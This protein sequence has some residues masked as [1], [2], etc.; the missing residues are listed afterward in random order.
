MLLVVAD[1][2]V[3]FLHRFLVAHPNLV[4]DLVDEAEVVADEDEPPFVV[5][6]G[7]GEGI[8]GLDV[9]MVRGL[10]EEEEV[11][12]RHA[13]HR[14]DDSALLALAQVAD[15]RGL[16][17]PGDAIAP[18]KRAPLL[19]VPRKLLVVRV[20]VLEELER[21]HL[22]LE[23]IDRVLMVLPDGEVHVP[24][25]GPLRRHELA[26][27][28]LEESRLARAVGAHERHPRVAV[29][30]EVQ[31]LVQVVL[32][33]P[34]VREADV[35][36]GHHGGRQL[37][38]VREGE[39][40][41]LLALH[42]RGEALRVHLVQ[43]L[44]LRLGLLHEVGVGPA[45]G[46]ELLDVLDV[47]LL[48]LVLLLL[49]DVV[50]GDRLLEGVVVAG[51]VVQLL[52][53]EPYG[54]RADAVEEVLAVRDDDEALV[55]VLQVLLEPH[56]RLE[57]EV[58]GRL[59]EQQQRRPHKKRPREGH[60]HAPSPRHV[61]RGAG[62]HLLAEPEPVQELRRADLKGR[63]VKLLKALVDGLQPF[64]LGAALSHDLLLKGLEP[65]QLLADVV[66]H[67]VQRSHFRGGNLV[68]KVVEVH[69]LW[70]RNLSLCETLQEVGFTTSVLANETI[71]P[72]NCKLDRTLLD[73][74]DTVQ[75]QA[76]AVNFDIASSWPRSQD[77]RN[78]THDPGR[79]LSPRI[80]VR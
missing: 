47:L 79:F 28:E 18:D 13:D 45:R 68:V 30:A 10:V 69:M 33:L 65:L 73:E 3:P 19:D 15:L 21:H 54:V 32:L 36:E 80:T 66:H 49:D 25:D 67:R 35:R 61:L 42:R 14:K 4:G 31:V 50:L 34:A 1:V 22:R 77:T 71:T 78:C 24:A 74:F 48:L 64:I 9:E 40:E 23:D 57:V 59:V 63:R 16:H 52:L 27:H 53:G 7:V 37:L 46:D 12:G 11:R 60:A 70:D 20:H 76:E 17:L 75:A 38:A 72:A 41:A 43:D 62:H 58:V 44:L 5:L 51:V 8:D 39:L 29:D 56:A 6:D 55:V 26:C 2:A